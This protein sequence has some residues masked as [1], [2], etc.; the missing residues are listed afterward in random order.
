MG[1]VIKRRTLFA[2][3]ATGRAGQWDLCI[4]FTRQPHAYESPF[5]AGS[6]VNVRSSSALSSSFRGLDLHAAVSRECGSYGMVEVTISSWLP[7]STYRQ[8]A[9]SPITGTS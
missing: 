8:T 1:T 4:C 6:M 9:C 7:G 2:L 3:L 5:V